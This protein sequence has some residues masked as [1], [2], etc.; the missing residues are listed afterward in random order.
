MTSRRLFLPAA[1]PDVPGERIEFRPAATAVNGRTAVNTS[2]AVACRLSEG[3]DAWEK[4][5]ANATERIVH[6]LIPLDKHMLLVGGAV[7]G[8]GNA[9]ALDCVKLADAGMKIEATAQKGSDS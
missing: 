7:A 6:R 5:G 3:G 2:E 4:V 1:G 9:A 8:W